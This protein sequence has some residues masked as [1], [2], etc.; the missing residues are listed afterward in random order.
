MRPRKIKWWM[1]NG[2]T[3]NNKSPAIKWWYWRQGLMI[4]SHGWVWYI[5][6][7]LKYIGL[8]F[9][10]VPRA[11]LW[12][13]LCKHQ[14]KHFLV[15]RINFYEPPPLPYAIGGLCNRCCQRVTHDLETY[16]KWYFET[17][18]EAKRE[19]DET[20]EWGRQQVLNA[21]SHP[22]RKDNVCSNPSN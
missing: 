4:R 9:L 3:L 13:P 5:G 19:L 12:R 22:I 11:L 16:N 17:H 18:P 20:N 10:Y 21:K 6:W 14:F 1:I 8:C 7:K 15:D 2:V